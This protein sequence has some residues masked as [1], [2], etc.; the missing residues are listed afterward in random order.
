[1]KKGFWIYLIFF[2]LAEAFF[3]CL[4]FPALADGANEGEASPS[5]K[6]VA[7]DSQ[8]V[9]QT[10]LLGTSLMAAG[11]LWLRRSCAPEERSA[12]CQKNNDHE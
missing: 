6:P 1:M 7:G 3:A 4:P 10:L 8:K 12:V 9:W 2:S 11:T 5:G